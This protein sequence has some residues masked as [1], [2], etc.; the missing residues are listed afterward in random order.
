MYKYI[1][2]VNGFFISSLNVDH[3]S[4]NI[5]ITQI[6][7]YVESIK[8]FFTFTLVSLYSK[9]YLNYLLTFL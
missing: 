1:V 9:K 5:P 6:L 3:L 7:K 8:D 2:N 4:Y